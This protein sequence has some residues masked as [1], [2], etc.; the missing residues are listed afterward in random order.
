M[1][2]LAESSS[3]EEDDLLQPEAASTQEELNFPPDNILPEVVDSCPLLVS[4]SQNSSELPVLGCP[5][6]IV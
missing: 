4:S 2:H 1:L 6:M 3:E 5:S